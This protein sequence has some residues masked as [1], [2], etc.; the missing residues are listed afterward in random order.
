MLVPG[1]SRLDGHPA[2]RAG[3][4]A[5]PPLRHTRC[6]PT[7]ARRRFRGRTRRTGSARTA[8]RARDAA[9]VGGGA[10]TG[11]GGGCWLSRGVYP[12]LV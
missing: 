9:P 8:S 3:R 6:R 11:G 10:A 2:A 12:Q 5:P 7:A 4:A 1:S